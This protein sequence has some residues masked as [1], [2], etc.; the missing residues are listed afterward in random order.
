MVCCGAVWVEA[1]VSLLFLL[2]HI[3]GG[4]Y[5][6]TLFESRRRRDLFTYE[7]ARV[8]P[9]FDPDFKGFFVIPLSGNL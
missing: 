6:R 2:W 1:G 3:W 9:F 7:N 4:G 5:P 8:S